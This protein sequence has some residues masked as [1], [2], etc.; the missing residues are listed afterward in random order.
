MYV[1]QI[2]AT[3]CRNKK[4]EKTVI[5]ISE[6]EVLENQNLSLKQVEPETSSA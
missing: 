3:K 6:S 5:L 2:A 1:L 4:K